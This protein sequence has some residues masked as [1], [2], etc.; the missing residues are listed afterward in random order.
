[1][2]NQQQI[3]HVPSVMLVVLATTL[4][5]TSARAEET[6][7]PAVTMAPAASEAGGGGSGPDDKKG[8]RLQVAADYFSY[9]ADFTFKGGGKYLDTEGT[10]EGDLLGATVSIGLPKWKDTSWLDFSYRAGDIDGNL[11]YDLSPVG[12][13]IAT[14]HV[15]TELDE[16]EVRYRSVPKG[17]NWGIGALYQNWETT[18]QVTSGTFSAQKYSVTDYLANIYIGYAKIWPISVK[19]DFGLRGEV[20]GGAGYA[21]T[22]RLGY[23]DNFLMDAEGRVTAFARYW[24]SLGGVQCNVF[25]EFGVKGTLYFSPGSDETF[26]SESERFYGYFSKIGLSLMF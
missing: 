20:G 24:F 1:M 10:K 14:T 22:S 4:A 16:F 21:S 6:L 7:S 15:V 12:G 26:K 17:F 23:D 8:W 9:F 25:G 13:G 18:E 19:V 3:N 5:G 11:N 2:K